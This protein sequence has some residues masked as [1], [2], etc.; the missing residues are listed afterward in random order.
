MRGGEF[1]RCSLRWRVS[2]RGLGDPTLFSGLT[3]SLIFRS[4]PPPTTCNSTPAVSRSFRIPLSYLLP[5]FLPST[6]LRLLPSPTADTAHCP[7]CCVVASP[8]VSLFLY[9]P[10]SPCP[11]LFPP[12]FSTAARPPR[13]ILY[14]YP[15]CITKVAAKLFPPS[16]PSRARPP[17]STPYWPTRRAG[18]INSLSLFVRAPLVARER[19]SSELFF[20]SSPVILVVSAPLRVTIYVPVSEIQ[21]RGISRSIAI[22]SRDFLI[23]E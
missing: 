18:S 10:S 4:P 16:L 6:V 1:W 20:R 15:A 11:L 14:N 8:G 5:P 19:D 22:V 3:P 23:Y 2:Y 21:R 17:F 7:E 13:S 9:L 12:P